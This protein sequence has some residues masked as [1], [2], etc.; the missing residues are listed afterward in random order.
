MLRKIIYP[1]F[2]TLRDAEKLPESAKKLL[3]GF[4]PLGCNITR[5]DCFKIELLR[6]RMIDRLES[7]SIKLS[8]DNETLIARIAQNMKHSIFPETN[9]Q[10]IRHET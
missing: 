3:W 2:T 9:K 8:V 7:T 1:A 5:F 4:Q 6:I 10:K